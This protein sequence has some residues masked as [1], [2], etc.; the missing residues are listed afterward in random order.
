M[1]TKKI[2]MRKKKMNK[3]GAVALSNSLL[4][5]VSLS[6]YFLMYLRKIIG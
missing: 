1:F 2:M 6:F 3:S 5:G 4:C